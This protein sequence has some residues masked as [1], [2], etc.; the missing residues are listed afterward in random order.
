MN[1]M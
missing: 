1:L